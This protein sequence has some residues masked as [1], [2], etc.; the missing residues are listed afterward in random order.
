MLLW[1]R[2]NHRRSQASCMQEGFSTHAI[3]SNRK[4]HS[5]EETWVDY[6]EKVQVSEGI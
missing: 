3:T 4:S 6:I 5:A 1:V 2:R